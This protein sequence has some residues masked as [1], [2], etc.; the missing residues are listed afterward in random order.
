MGIIKKPEQN[1]GIQINNQSEGNKFAKLFF[2]GSFN[3]A[4]KYGFANVLVPIIKDGICRTSTNIINFWVNGDKQP[5]AMQGRPNV[6]YWSGAN[7]QRVLYNNPQVKPK[8]V[9][10]GYTFGE[11]EFPVDKLDVAE[12]VMADVRDTFNTYGLVSVA[13][14]LEFVNA[15]DKPDSRGQ[16]CHLKIN[17]TDYKYGWRNIDGMRLELTSKSKY[18]LKLPRPVPLD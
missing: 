2:A 5:T 8:P 1:S 15:N 17:H 10:I 16:T 6:S 7:Q 3:D 9:D 12:L 11:L 14:L 13:N 18:A 4:V